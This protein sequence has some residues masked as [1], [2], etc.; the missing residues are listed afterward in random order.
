MIFAP[1]FWFTFNNY[2]QFKNNPNFQRSQN[3]TLKKNGLLAYLGFGDDL[4]VNV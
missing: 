2:N 1:F 3:R 4:V